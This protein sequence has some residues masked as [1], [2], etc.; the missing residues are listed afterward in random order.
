MS[1]R[2]LL[3]KGG[4]VL[5]MDAVLG[6]IAG[7]DVL[8]EDDR[9]VDVGRDIE[10]VDC[11]K[12]DAAGMLVLPGFVDTHRHTWQTQLRGIAA[13][14]T[15]FDYVACMRLCYSA[16]YRADDAWLGNHAGALEALESG[17]TSLVDHCHIVNTPEHADAAIDGLE[18]T[19]IRAVWCYGMFGNPVRAP[20][21]SAAV[22]GFETPAW[23][24]EDARRIRTSRLSCDDGHVRM[25]IAMNEVEAFPTAVAAAEIDFARELAIGRLSCHVAMGAASRDARLVERLAEAGLLGPELLFVHGASL[26]DRELKLIAEHGASVSVTP[27]TEVQMGMGHPATGRV[28]AAGACTSLGIDI[29]SNYSGDMFAQMRLGLQ[30]ERLRRNAQLE[31]RALAPRRLQFTARDILRIATLEGARAAGLDDRVGSLRPGKQADLI[32]LRGDAL[33]MAPVNDAAAAIVLCANASN[34]DSVFVAGRAVKRAGR[35][36]GVD[37]ARIVSQ[38]ETSRDRIL[39]S[40]GE[41]S[42][43]GLREMIAPLF[44]LG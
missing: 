20:G 27:E 30:M 39:A 29:V 16:G 41:T 7:G 26:T 13:D 3:I 18:Q 12:V 42:L 37:A 21:K 38:L 10:L 6:D 15:L 11:E 25:G 35:L 36:V 24:F 2:R 28:L 22:S 40:A 34:V 32:L 4:H 5:T 43:D 17:I 31:S 8:V 14:W 19:G 9:I 23:H 44:P 33:N 1:G